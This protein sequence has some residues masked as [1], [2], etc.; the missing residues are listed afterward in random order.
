[1]H[2]CIH[3][4][5]RTICV[6]LHQRQQTFFGRQGGILM[7]KPTRTC[8]RSCQI[9]FEYSC[10][11]LHWYSS[12]GIATDHGLNAQGSS[13]VKDKRVLSLHSVQIGSGSH[14]ASI[15][16]EYRWSFPRG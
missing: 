3:T 10:M 14:A 16:I 5:A 4:G 7:G 9:K 13:S 2:T 8:H 1:M 6:G 12:V 15:C 11:Y